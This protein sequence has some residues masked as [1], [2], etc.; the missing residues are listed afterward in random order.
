MNHTA[1][2]STGPAHKRLFA[3]IVTV[4]FALLPC[5]VRADIV[6]EWNERA[7]VAM[8]AE[9]VTGG[10][11]PARILTIM[12]A[13]MFDAVSA[14]DKRY[15][16]YS[17]ATLDA[18]D[19]SPEVAVHAAARRALAELLP[20]Q[21]PM[22]DA[23][24]DAATLRSPDGA[25]R[26][27][28]IDAGEKAAMSLVEQRKTDGANSPNTYRPITAPGVY[29]PTTMLTLTF[30]ASVKPLALTSVSQFRP[31]P[32]YELSSAS[33]ARD[34]NETKELGSTKSTQRSAW[35]TETARFWVLV[36]TPAWNQAAR[37]L[38]A[39]KPQPLAE[40]ARLFA[41][42]NM[43]IADA[44]LAVFDAK[45]QY[46]FWRP[47]TAIRNGDRDG[48]DAT[49]RDAGW[50]PVI[51]TPLHPEYPC[52]HC[53]V[54]GAAGAVLKSVFGTGQVEEF[55][56]TFA[57]MPGITRRYT[58]IQQLEEEVSMA[59]IWGGVHFRTSNEVGHAL[60]KQVGDYVLSNY[61][62]PIR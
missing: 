45:Y 19:A 37:S 44:Y 40:S 30:V 48:N 16:S 51:D 53:T 59:R 18:T 52:A 5:A 61:F 27:A 10:F 6:T 11:G 60:G 3:G 46:N 54:D 56:L 7:F 34:Y 35:Q 38:S 33:W 9:K 17:G 24:F 47:I 39:S 21:K 8:G 31:G 25:A 29:V 22:L 58:S 42:L 4:L 23:A 1:K 26:A 14:V 50:T 32:P 2:L 28:G 55:T 57:D 49:E 36:G 15:A 20:R 62:R 12:H 43:A 41:H 13:A